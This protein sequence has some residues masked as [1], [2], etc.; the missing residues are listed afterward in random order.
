MLRLAAVLLAFLALTT[1]GAAAP[2]GRITASLL[3]AKSG[4]TA[5][6]PWTALVSIRDGRRP[7]AARS[8]TLSIGG[9]L[10]RRTF[11]AARA[12]R[13]GR[14]R[15]RVLFPA[16]GPWTLD[17]RVGRRSL[18]LGN[19]TVRGSG[20]RIPAPHGLLAA[21][22]HGDLIVA[23]RSGDAIYEVDLH[24]RATTRVGRGFEH[25]LALSFGPGGFL[26]VGDDRRIWRFEPD[27]RLTPFAGNGTRGLGGTAAPRPRR[28]WEATASSPSTPPAGSISPSTTTGSG[29]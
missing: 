3:T 14:Y 17:V 12:G 27:G 9:E 29:S 18:R 24:T 5:G 13:P 6:R 7:L 4:V 15:A 28:S 10:G 25:A 20:P 16:G 26:Y 1:A 22:E 23:D 21:V 8:V 19:L 2:Q 11:K